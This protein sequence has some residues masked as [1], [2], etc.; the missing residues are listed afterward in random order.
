MAKVQQ[1]LGMIETK[2]FI[3]LL[4]A[5]DATDA[6]AAIE[7]ERGLDFGN[8]GHRFEARAEVG[9]AIAPWIAARPMA[10]V[11]ARF[12]ELGV[13]WGRYQS[14]L[15]LVADDPRCS[16]DSELFREVDQPGIG[17]YLTPGSPVAFDGVL[18]VEPHPAPRLGE[19]TDEV[20][21]VRLGLTSAE[22][23]ILHDEGVVQQA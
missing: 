14:F 3:A 20:L 21:T 10:E 5:T 13:C 4:E 23:G 11:A 9:A 12:D 19:H 7:T 17:S 2:G 18:P 15:E 16:T 6:V 1:A 8:E 22:I